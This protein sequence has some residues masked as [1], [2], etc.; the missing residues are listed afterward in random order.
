MSVLQEREKDF[1]LRL[2]K[3]R[4]KQRISQLDLALKAELSQNIV[5]LIETGKR[6]PNLSTIFKLCD[7]LSISPYVLFKTQEKEREEIKDEIRR[8]IQKL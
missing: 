5:N 8:L 4:E 3:E 2:K 1:A 6:V 7:A